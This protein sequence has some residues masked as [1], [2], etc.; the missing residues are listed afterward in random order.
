LYV[1]GN[2]TDIAWAVA[3]DD[4]VKINKVP[5]M[6]ASMKARGHGGTF[7]ELNG[8]VGTKVA[9]DWL[10]WQL[11]NDKQAAKTFIGKDCGLCVDPAWTVQRKGFGDDIIDASLRPAPVDPAAQA[12]AE[13]AAAEVAR[14]ND[15]SAAAG[16][17]TT[18]TTK[19]GELMGDPAAKAIVAKYAPFILNSPHVVYP[20]TL[21][22]L[23]FLAASMVSDRMLADMDAEFLKLPPKK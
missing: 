11:H 14:K 20:Q 12:A 10:S 9:L 7:D 6:F 13:A 2:R 22:Q 23:Q 15:V 21:K 16:H 1:L 4:F 17:Y 18:T 5:V 8:G 3:T 19:I